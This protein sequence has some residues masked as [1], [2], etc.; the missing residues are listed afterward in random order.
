MKILSCALLVLLAAGSLSGCGSAPQ[1]ATG[2]SQP[3][4]AAVTGVDTPK[5]VSVVT[6]N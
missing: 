4:P 2:T 3:P 5:A 1:P 6:A